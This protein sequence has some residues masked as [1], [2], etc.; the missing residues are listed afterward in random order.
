M[1]LISIITAG[2]R[3]LGQA[4]M[5]TVDVIEGA[6]RLRAEMQGRYRSYDS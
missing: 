6:W 3:R 2:L 1:A 4:V 5:F